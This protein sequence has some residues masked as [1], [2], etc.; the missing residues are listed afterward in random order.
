MLLCASMAA[1]RTKLLLASDAEL[2]DDSIL[3]ALAP[4]YGSLHCT[5]VGTV[6]RFF[7][8]VSEVSSLEKE[9]CVS[10]SQ[11]GRLLSNRNHRS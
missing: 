10:A 9:E 5:S 1:A 11:G 7:A 6:H 3:A 2:E 8:D 4:S